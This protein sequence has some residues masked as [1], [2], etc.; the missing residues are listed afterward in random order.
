MSKKPQNHKQN[1]VK[2]FQSFSPKYNIMEAFSDFSRIAAI[3]LSNAIPACHSRERE[4][5]YMQ[6]VKKYR[7]EE[8]DIF[9]KILA[10]LTFALE[11]EMTDVLGEVFHILGLH[12]KW[13]GQFFTPQVICNFMG[14]IQ[15]ANMNEAIKEKGY[16]SVCEPACGSGAMIIG[17]AYGMI[18][19]G[20]NPQKQ[21]LAECKD[22]DS[23]CVHMTYIQLSLLGIPAIIT[24]GNGLTEEKIS[25]WYTPFYVLNRWP[26]PERSKIN[27]SKA[28]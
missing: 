8:V 4:R 3:S 17:M 19:S 12:N 27:I 23:R 10:E 2:L 18:C 20:Y 24:Q 28:A 15:T 26:L 21:L 7:K 14:S 22:I 25:V 5:L 6:T 11:H 1:I 16:F 13:V 9:V